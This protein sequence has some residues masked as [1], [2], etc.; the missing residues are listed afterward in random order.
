MSEVRSLTVGAK[1][2]GE[3]VLGSLS[4][5]NRGAHEI[6][7]IAVGSCISKAANV[8]QILEGG[9]DTLTRGASIGR[10]RRNHSLF[11]SSTISLRYSGLQGAVGQEKGSLGLTPDAHFV[12]F[13]LYHLIL[14]HL[15]AVSSELEIGV[16]DEKPLLRIKPTFNSFLCSIVEPHAGDE[17]KR[18]S[19]QSDDLAA[20]FYRAGLV[21]SARWEEVATRLG[22]S[23]DVV[24]GL[25]TN[26]L[27]NCAVT[28]QLLDAFP[29]TCHS[30][31]VQSP[32]WI[33]LVVPSTVMHEIEQ[34]T[35]SRDE[36]GGLTDSGRIGYR[37]LQE[38]LELHQSKDISG[39][40]L[41][42]AGETD[43]VLDARVELR[44]LREDFFKKNAPPGI[45]TMRKGSAGDTWIRDQFKSFLR[46]LNF[47]KAAY[48]LS[49]DK[50][51]CALGQAEGLRSLYFPP[52]SDKSFPPSLSP[53]KVLYEE[54]ELE[55][56]VP[57][58]KLIYELAVQFG[59]I[60]VAWGKNRVWLN[61]D[62]RGDSLEHWVNRELRVNQADI[63]K[64]VD[65]YR[66][67]AAVSLSKV[68]S[69]WKGIMKNT[70]DW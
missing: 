70:M 7:L 33:L 59:T 10:F 12:A 22:Q 49:A 66:A 67:T 35:N 36:N 17:W 28:Q 19:T 24:L 63:A 40:S 6:Q 14:D 57:L 45:Q 38:I 69:E 56:A 2:T 62:R 43:P 31:Y 55:V 61:C 3:Y 34:R 60:S 9:F 5:F 37:A 8:A 51:N 4:L 16:R 13:P 50:S 29:F 58:G 27:L 30:D 15:L 52:A 32:N 1:Q 25:D 48:F 39:L 18:R 65:A 47:H 41:L 68:E 21:L 46:H 44:G 11:T 23:D 54:N 64:M 26:I 53:P 20:A 42:I